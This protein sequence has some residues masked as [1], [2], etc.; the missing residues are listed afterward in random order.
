MKLFVV[1][2]ACVALASAEYTVKTR[3][4]LLAYRDECVKSL[5]IPAETVEKFK[6]WDF[7]DTPLVHQYFACVFEKFGFYTKE[8]GFNVGFIHKQVDPE[9][10]HENH[11]EHNELH[12]KIQKCADIE[13]SDAYAY[14]AG[15]CF[16]KEQIHLVKKSVE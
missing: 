15:K 9:V 1:V 10:T 11:G 8:G 7:E 13:K 16:M 4:N 2:F 5:S 6:K 3:E 14:N 12:A